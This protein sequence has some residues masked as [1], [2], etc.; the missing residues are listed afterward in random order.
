MI[1][2][3]ISASITLVHN[4]GDSGI[5]PKTPSGGHASSGMIQQST[6]TLN[7]NNSYYCNESKLIGWAGRVKMAL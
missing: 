3:L 6:D 1:I 5:T 7:R 4:W 2:V